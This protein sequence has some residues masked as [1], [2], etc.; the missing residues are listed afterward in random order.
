[1]VLSVDHVFCLLVVVW[2]TSSSNGLNSDS[3][4]MCEF[5]CHGCSMS[6]ETECDPVVGVV[7]VGEVSVV[8]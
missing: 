5:E 4:G 1:M 8:P 7:V 2:T 3:S 6:V